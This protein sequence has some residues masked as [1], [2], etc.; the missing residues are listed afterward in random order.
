MTVSKLT[1]LA[2]AALMAGPACAQTGTGL[3]VELTAGYDALTSHDNF[4]DI[5]DTLDGLRL[6]G[7]IGYDVAMGARLRLGIEAGLGFS[8]NDDRTAILARDRLNLATARDL[9][10]SARAGLLVSSRTIAYVKAGYA[11]SRITLR[12]DA[13]VG[14]SYDSVRSAANG[15]GLRLGAGLE[16]ALSGP[17]HVKAEYRWTRYF[18]DYAYQERPTRQQILAGVGLRF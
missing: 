16:H 10:I 11:N 12:Y 8:L 2:A 15:D 13:N 1:L 7:A 9:D 14:G 6:G 4:E 5:P 17:F 3:R 18:G